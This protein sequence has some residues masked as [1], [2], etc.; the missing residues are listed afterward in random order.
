VK[1][2]S[3]NERETQNGEISITFTNRAPTI[4]DK[5]AIADKISRP[6]SMNELSIVEQKNNDNKLKDYLL[7]TQD[8][9]KNSPESDVNILVVCCGDALNM[10]VWREYLVGSMNGFFTEHSLL[11]HGDFNRVDYVLLTNIQD[12][13]HKYFDVVSVINHWELGMSFNLLYPNKYSIRNRTVIGKRDLEI[14]NSIFPNQNIDFQNYMNDENDIPSGSDP[15]L[16]DT[17]MGIKWYTDKFRELGKH[18][19]K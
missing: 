17:I 6:L 12:R 8:K 16:K 3:R 18:Y 19:F 10:H 15:T 5:N 14:M 4:E 13:H 9:V 7:S 2:P 11:D 1:C